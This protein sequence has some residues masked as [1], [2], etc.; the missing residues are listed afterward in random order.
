MG[1]ADLTQLNG[2]TVTQTPATG[3][4]ISTSTQTMQSELINSQKRT[5]KAPYDSQIII[6]CKLISSNSGRPKE[7]SIL[8]QLYFSY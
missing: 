2:P 4:R 7:C 1:R 3:S 8:N 6:I 5:R